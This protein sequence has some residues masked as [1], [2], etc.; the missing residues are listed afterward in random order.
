MVTILKL[1]TPNRLQ[2]RFFPAN[3]KRSALSR[4]CAAVLILCFLLPPVTARAAI[5]AR[6]FKAMVAT[7]HPLATEAALAI[8]KK[9]GNA[10]DAAI[11]AQWVLNVVE[12]QSSGIGGGGFFLFYD[13]KTKRVH[14]LD[15]RETA[16]RDATPDMFLAANG[17]PLPFFPDRITGGL[18]VGTP[19]VLR[20]LKTAHERFSSKQIAFESLFQPA[21]DIANQGFAVSS[22][23]SRMIDGQKERLRLFPESKKIFL[24]AE[25]QALEPGTLL[26]QPDLAKTFKLLQEKGVA[27]F[28]EGAIADA[29]VDTVRF[30]QFNPG[31]LTRQDLFYYTVK[32]RDG[33]YGRYRGYDILSM[34][35]PSSGG[36]TL[37]ETLNILSH[38]DL[39]SMSRT[40]YF[41]HVFS[42]SQKLAFQDR[43]KY[44][45]D[46]DFSKLPLGYLLSEDLAREHHSKIQANSVVPVKS[47]VVTDP[48]SHTSHISIVDEMGNMVSFTTTIEHVFGSA[49]VVPGYGFLLN[50]E[51]TDFDAGPFPPKELLPPNA[52]GPEKRPRSSMTPLFVFKEGKPF[53]VAGSPGGSTIIVTM[54][55]LLVNLIDF[56]MNAENAVREP[57]IMNR[58]GATELETALFSKGRL[59]D[60]LTARGH[61]VVRNAFY[62]NAQVIYFDENT[63]ELVG[64]SDPRGEGKAA[65]Y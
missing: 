12:P 39:G 3:L 27:Y 17:Q 50:N 23:L 54:L 45:G 62:G 11:A 43:N 19:G 38:F 48:G 59:R 8:L 15:G 47:G 16:P 52:A 18:S 42:E 29:I 58:D 65:G 28:Y 6:A 21:I 10:A 51:L 2:L 32:E 13:V 7:A 22:R 34:G 46:P 9:G 64:V 41:A 37:I 24:N 53:L 30:A 20:L 55:N 60:A 61:T 57:K 36:V 40:G 31:R 49:M 26:Q 44:L 33:V 56:H 25:G 63:H 4:C 1:N 35:P 5:S 14:C